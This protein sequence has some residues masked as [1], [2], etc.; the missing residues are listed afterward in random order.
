MNT[1][2]LDEESSSLKTRGTENRQLVS[3]TKMR[4][5]RHKIWWIEFVA[6]RF[7]ISWPREEK[8]SKRRSKKPREKRWEGGNK[9]CE[10]AK[11]KRF[12][13]LLKT[14]KQEKS[15]EKKGQETAKAEQEQRLK[16]SPG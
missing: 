2:K 1:E 8:W 6:A 9:T 3:K 4:H 15:E 5:L 14:S 16:A 10:K 11:E 7:A 12:E 13:A